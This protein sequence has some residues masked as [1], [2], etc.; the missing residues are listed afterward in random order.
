MSEHLRGKWKGLI[1]SKESSEKFILLI[2]M[3]LTLFWVSYSR[4]TFS[5]YFSD[6][7]EGYNFSGIHFVTTDWFSGLEL[8]QSSENYSEHEKDSDM[9]GVEKSMLND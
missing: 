7:R 9:H 1:A 3:H 2:F 6:P 5:I 8:H 4:D